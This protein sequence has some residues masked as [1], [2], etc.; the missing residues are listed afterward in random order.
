MIKTDRK[1]VPK[2]RTCAQDFLFEL[3][4]TWKELVCKQFMQR[5]LRILLRK[6]DAHITNGKH[7]YLKFCTILNVSLLTLL[8]KQFDHMLNESRKVNSCPSVTP[9]LP[10]L[11]LPPSNPSSK[12]ETSG[13]FH[14]MHN[15]IYISI[16]L[17]FIYFF[18]LI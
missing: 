16:F 18:F 5:Y 7:S 6:N 8:C 3:G 10:A 4:R 13:D 9:S 12:L 1:R 15:L 2:T 17:Y 14:L 11:P